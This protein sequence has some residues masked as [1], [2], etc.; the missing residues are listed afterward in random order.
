MDLYR[1]TYL[2]TLNCFTLVYPYSINSDKLKYL[3]FDSPIPF[4][5]TY[6]SVPEE[7]PIPFN[8]V[9]YFWITIVL[10]V[11]IANTFSRITSTATFICMGWLRNTQRR[12]FIQD[13]LLKP[14]FLPVLCLSKTDIAMVRK[15][16]IA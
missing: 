11:V 8:E 6:S 14:K 15:Y 7:N 4:D 1:W 12:D 13:D 2:Y 3:K 5:M 10:Q 16:S 9:I